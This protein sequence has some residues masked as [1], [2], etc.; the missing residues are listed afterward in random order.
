MTRWLILI[1]LAI[2]G[3]YATAQAP[4]LPPDINPTT[5]S[6]FGPVTPADLDEAGQKALAA[7]ANPAQPGPGPGAAGS[8]SP[9]T[10]EGRGLLG[11]ALGVPSGENF[12][13][14]NRIYQLVVLITAREIDQQYEWS[15]HEPMGLRQGLGETV[16]DVVQYDR[17]AGRR[18]GKDR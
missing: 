5:L 13:A 6:R 7:R 11:R 12:P 15:A 16:I 10:S 8:Y 18:A 14:G 17:S 1:A 3:I 4:A 2:S 9:R